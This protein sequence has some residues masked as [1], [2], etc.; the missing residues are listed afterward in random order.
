MT[1]FWPSRDAAVRRLS[2]QLY[3]SRQAC[4]S[5]QIR[6]GN[7][8]ADGLG[9]GLDENRAAVAEPGRGDGPGPLLMVI[10]P[11]TALAAALPIFTRQVWLEL[12]RTVG[13]GLPALAAAAPGPVLARSEPV[14]AAA[15]RI[16]TVAPAPCRS[17]RPRAV[18]VV[19]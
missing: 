14:A 1:T 11:A 3:G 4:E 7:P 9:H 17:G 15:G 12:R 2:R 5:H 19:A 6:V 13:T 18:P 10:V 16:R 8:L